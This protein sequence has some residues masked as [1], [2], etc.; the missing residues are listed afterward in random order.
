[1]SDEAQEVMLGREAFFTGGF[2]RR[3]MEVKVPLLGGKV[4]IGSVSESERQAFETWLRDKKGQIRGDRSKIVRVKYLVDNVYTGTLAAPGAR[5]FGNTDVQ[6]LVDE[7]LDF[8]IT[9]VLV[10]KITDFIG[11]GNSDVED[12]AKNS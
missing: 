8:A 2:K 5:M 12:L 6:A 9:H 11:L 3:Y 7:D 10:D 4:L 1:M